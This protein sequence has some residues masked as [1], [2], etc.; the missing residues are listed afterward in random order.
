[1]GRADDNDLV[2]PGTLPNADTVS[3]HHAQFRRDQA[4]YIVR[5][6]GTPNGLTLN[7]RHTNHNLLQDGD[8]VSF[9]AVE[10]VFRKSGETP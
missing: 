6:L 10:A 7:G 2:V 9:G 3:Q 8:R 4:D 5:D 1:L